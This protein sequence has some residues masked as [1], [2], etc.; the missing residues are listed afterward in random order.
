M[1]LS[2]VMLARLFAFVEPADLNPRG[3]VYYPDLVAA[4][5]EH[6]G[7]MK[8]PKNAED[9]DEA[10][11]VQ[12]EMGRAGDVTISKIQIYQQGIVVDTTSSTGDSDRIL[13]EALLWL[14]TEFGLIYKPDMISRRAYVSQLTFYSDIDLGGL[15][16]ALSRLAERIS[17][18]LPQF[19]GREIAYEPTGVYVSYD[20]MEVKQAPSNFSIERRAETP[21]SENKYFSVAPLPTDDHIAVL[22]AFEADIMSQSQA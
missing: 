21:F 7:F 18:R 12:F 3:K 15:N 2:A 14:S 10:K 16:V 4:L 22:E 11:G 5:A 9:F 1:Q 19:F 20:A 13:D 17:K 8:Y 6:Y